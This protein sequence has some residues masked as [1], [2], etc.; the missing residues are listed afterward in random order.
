MVLVTKARTPTGNVR[1]PD[2][3]VS[4]ARGRVAQHQRRPQTSIDT[5][6]RLRLVTPPTNSKH[7]ITVDRNQSQRSQLP[8]TPETSRGDDESREL[9]SPTRR[10]RSASAMSARLDPN[11]P[12]RV[13]FRKYRHV[14][15]GKGGWYGYHCSQYL[16]TMG[17]HSSCDRCQRTMNNL[18][19]TWTTDNKDDGVCNTSPPAETG[20]QS[21]S[22]CLR[23]ISALSTASPTAVGKNIKVIDHSKER[24]Q[25]LSSATAVTIKGNSIKQRGVNSLRH[26]TT[27]M[28]G[29]NN[30]DKKTSKS[31]RTSTIESTRT[32]QQKVVEFPVHD[33]VYNNQII[34]DMS[35]N[36]LYIHGA[37]DI[38]SIEKSRKSMDE[39]AA[40]DIQVRGQLDTNRNGENT[41]PRMSRSRSNSEVAIDDST[42]SNYLPRRESSSTFIGLLS[43]EGRQAMDEA[44]QEQ[45]QLN[46]SPDSVFVEKQLQQLPPA[47]TF[48]GTSAEETVW[49][50]D[51]I[52]L[53]GSS[54]NVFPE[55]NILLSDDDYEVYEDDCSTT[56]LEISRAMSKCSEWLSKRT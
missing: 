35:S 30:G 52:S 48:F 6:T 36:G 34:T 42:S 21:V 46:V 3:D 9:M 53:I 47:G 55:K 8:K 17:H 37:I 10:R 39:S 28:E 13:M 41:S 32:V 14:Y 12:E 49:V 15:A 29:G 7:P 50:F 22:F 24:Q 25:E 56:E 43:R 1:R 27:N 20:Q 45:K 26:R 31:N 11:L 40:I 51:R 23:G 33:K 4:S 5:S 19:S 44:R 38:D 2:Q 16:T 18:Q 54:S